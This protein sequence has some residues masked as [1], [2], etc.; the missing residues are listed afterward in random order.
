M[1]S[2]S[3]FFDDYCLGKEGEGTESPAKHRDLF[4][5]KC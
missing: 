1:I 2:F 4:E 5:G 3:N